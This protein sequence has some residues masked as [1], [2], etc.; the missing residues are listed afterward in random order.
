MRVPVQNTLIIPFKTRSNNPKVSPAL[1]YE[2]VCARHTFALRRGLRVRSK[3]C[4]KSLEDSEQ[5][6]ATRHPP[7]LPPRSPARKRSSTRKSG[8]W[9]HVRQ[10]CSAPHTSRWWRGSDAPGTEGME[11][12]LSGSERIGT[13][14]F[15]IQMGEVP[16]EKCERTSASSCRRCSL[17]QS[18]WDTGT[19]T[20]K[21]HRESGWFREEHLAP[22]VQA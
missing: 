2:D 1:K 8:V 20:H 6:F 18:R 13:T 21:H 3:N 7:I 9:S 17:W 5:R 4:S 14:T 22:Q 16:P 11:F 10:H 19:S 12:A 15:Y